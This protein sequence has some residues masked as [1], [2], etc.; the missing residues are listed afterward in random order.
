MTAIGAVDLA[1][2]DILGKTLGVPVYGLLGGPSRE[3]VT[4]YG[5]GN[6]A[7]LEGTVA[8]V[9]RYPGLGYKAIRAPSGGPGPK[10]GYGGAPGSKPYEP[11]RPGGRP[12]EENWGTGA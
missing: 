6:G 5:H 9:A 7:D 4:A 8:A 3:F 12:P 11:A 10:K 1:L 2:W